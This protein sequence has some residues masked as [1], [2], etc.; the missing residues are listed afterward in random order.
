M[1]LMDFGVFST[2]RLLIFESI[3]NNAL[4]IY[5]FRQASTDLSPQFRLRGRLWHDVLKGCLFVE[6]LKRRGLVFR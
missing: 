4:P 6:S 3:L 1:L 2:F 5:A